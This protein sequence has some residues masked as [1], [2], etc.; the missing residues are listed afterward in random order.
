MSSNLKSY[1]FITLLATVLA[2]AIGA[3]A[4]TLFYGGDFDP[5]NP[6]AN[7]LANENDAIVGGSPYG[8]AVYQN[9][10][11]ANNH[12]WQ[13]S[14]L[15]TNQVTNQA[16]P[17]N[18][19]WE[20]RSGLSEGNGGLLLASGTAADSVMTNGVVSTNT[21]AANALLTAGTYWFAVV[22]QAPNDANRSFTGNTFGLGAIGTQIS[23]QQF[24]NSS[25]F[26]ANFTNADN[27]GVFPAFSQGVLGRDMSVPEPSS[28]IRLGSGVLGLAGVLR[29][30][31]NG[32]NS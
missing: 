13:V 6:N 24:W 20:I 15:F 21:V 2:F 32:G 18:A 14:G 17:A 30:R 8:A 29:R 9:F 4:T 25:F 27:E 28:L 31:L 26:M 5:N 1:G 16:P 3:N 11:I 12:Q 10:V 23:D 19:Y 22:P 7:G